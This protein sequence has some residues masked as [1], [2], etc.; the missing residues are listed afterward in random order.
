MTPSPIGILRSTFVSDPTPI[1]GMPEL[2]KRVNTTLNPSWFYVSASP[3]N[4]Y[5]FLRNFLHA[6]YP[7][8]PIILR[9]A[10]W[11]DLGGFLTS[12]TQ[13]TEA[14]KSS[15][16]DRIHDCLPKRKVLCVGDSTQSDPEAYGDI[17]R[18]YKGW[19]KAI[20]IRKV[21]DVAEMQGTDKNK[22]ERFEKAFKD[23]PREIWKTFE[24]PEELY[25][26]VDAVGGT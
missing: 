26:A 21:T 11:Q 3:Y 23:V 12:L 22:D 4:L 14:Y 20:F 19:V 16:I 18:K 2:Y 13:G 8:G 1:R 10:S 25:R 5:P 7:P 6:H 17:A 15:R 24:D 9:D